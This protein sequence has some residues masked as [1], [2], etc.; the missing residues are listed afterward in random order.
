MVVLVVLQFCGNANQLFAAPRHTEVSIRGEDF[1]I[2]GQPTYAGRN[3]N[4]HRIEG[5]L[6][7]SRMVQGIFD[8]QNPDTV[9]RWNY[10]DGKWDADRNTREFMAA[11]PEWRSHGLLAFTLN[12][13]GGS[14]YGYSREQPWRNSAFAPDGSLRT[15]Y[16]S[17]LEKILNR[18]DELGMV[19]I[20]GYFYQAQDRVLTNETAVLK[21]VDGATDWVLDHGY[22]N[23]IVEINN[24]CD[25]HYVNEILQPQRVHELILR[26]QKNSRGDFH[27]LASTSYSG[28]LPKANVAT[29]ADFILVHGNGVRKNPAR[30]TESMRKIRAMLGDQPKPIVSNE[31]D[32]YD[33][34]QPTNNFVAAVSEHAA[35]GF[36][37]YRRKDEKFNE[38]FQSVPGDWMIGSERKRAFFKSLS[39]I[40]GEGA[41]MHGLKVSPNHRQLVDAETGQ[42]VFILAD[43]AWNLNA[44][45][46]DEVEIYLNRRA[47]QGFNVV[48]F[49]LN[50]SPQGDETNA[51]G[52]A[53]YIG[54]GKAE[55][56]P[57]YFE[58]CDAV[59]KKS[60]KR[61]LYVMLYAMWAGEKAGTMNNY[62]AEQ[63]NKI[64][65]ELGEHF[66]GVANVILC[67]GGEASPRYIEVERVNAIGRGLKD[68]CAGENLVT[69]HPCSGNSSSK[70]FADSPWL[71]F[72][73][74]QAKS[75][76]G[77]VNA[78][79]D[80]A[81]LV[82]KDFHTTPLKPTMMGEHRYETGTAEDPVIQ[83]R[84]LY[85]CVF[86]GAFGHA[87]GHNALWQMTPHTGKPWMLKGW[88]P[89]VTNWMDA[90]DT[91]AVRQ[92]A[93][94]RAFL[95][96]HPT[97]DFF[98]DQTLVLSGQGEDVATRIQAMRDGEPGK[99]D[100][101][102]VMA[103]IS[104][105]RAVTIDTAVIS[106]RSLS[107]S[108]FNPA[109]GESQILQQEI[110][111]L[112]NFT[113]EKTPDGADGV[114]VVCGFPRQ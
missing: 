70:F 87:Y 104:S 30:I 58:Y 67:V 32:N 13:Q 110:P 19:V 112:K 22:R 56:N 91:P 65:R 4:G 47:A 37:D 39:E 24:E 44:L 60:A 84:S 26:V 74:S 28:P 38:G 35:W 27:L 101:A 54:A 95:R 108:W 77:A 12:L 82:E 114:L 3:W 92:L 106:A 5:L 103:Y 89:G 55:L 1:Y 23:V 59:V 99:N 29:N 81:A 40:T 7:N 31:D 75:G 113:L 49:A 9:A 52:H 68:G 90:L 48:M 85:Q 78:A 2:N 36:F 109:T 69:V 21:A 93:N 50:F 46:L 86:A 61:G 83:R 88:N 97:G 16:F 79:Y 41:A 42:P 71:D 66:R 94:I 17:R 10:P 20:L 25:Q 34:D 15:E 96:E 80:A 8:D 100:A 11:M 72:Y 6:L 43:T 33:F 63:L 105:S 111:N 76:T 18:A 62:T 57:A 98:P 45:K 107:V 102:S 64:G 73:M 51:Y 53:A 14:P